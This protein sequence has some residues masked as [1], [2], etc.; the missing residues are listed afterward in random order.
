[1]KKPFPPYGAKVFLHF[2][3]PVYNEERRKLREGTLKNRS[4]PGVQKAERYEKVEKKKK[5]I[6]TVQKPLM[7]A[8]SPT[9]Q[10]LSP[11]IFSPFLRGT[12]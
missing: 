8:H 1:M 4:S 6:Q 11:R 9:M 5:T 2:V 12:G 10:P 7:G 3:R